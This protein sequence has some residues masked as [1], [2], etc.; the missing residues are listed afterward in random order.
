MSNEAGTGMNTCTGGEVI[1]E[2]PQMRAR[3]DSIFI[4]LWCWQRNRNSRSMRMRIPIQLT[5]VLI[6]WIQADTRHRVP[7]LKLQIVRK[8]RQALCR[9]EANELPSCIHVW[10]T[11]IRVQNAQGRN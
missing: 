6:C 11:D 2:M 10:L 9:S 7:K 4:D 1:G 3:P 8:I 5:L